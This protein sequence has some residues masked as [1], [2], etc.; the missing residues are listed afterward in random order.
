MRTWRLAASNIGWQ[1]ADDERVL[2]AMADLGYEGLEIAPTRVIADEPYDHLDDAARF[3]D[4]VGRRFGLA[5]P[6]IQSIWR[7]RTESI[8]DSSGAETLLSATE[9]AAAFAEAVG[10]ESLVFGCPRNRCVPEGRDPAEADGFLAACG[11]ACARHGAVL[12]LEANPPIYDTNFLTVTPKAYAK[13]SELADHGVRLNFDL[14]TVIANGESAGELYEMAPLVS[15][16]HLSEPHLAPPLAA[17]REELWGALREAI[18]ASSWAGYVSVEMAAL[19][20]EAA[21]S[22]LEQV[23]ALFG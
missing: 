23:A 9:G 6:S 1:A 22:V 7:G 13:A 15:H 4:D 2:S 14:G 3:A 8:F 17:G 10:A 20:A 5:I 11:D 16:V 18:E 12:A 21:I 19:D